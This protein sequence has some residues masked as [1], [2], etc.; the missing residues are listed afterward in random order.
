MLIKK[1]FFDYKYLLLIKSLFAKF[2]FALG[3]ISF[4]LLISVFIYYF[5][6]GLSKTYGLKTVIIK[7]NEKILDRYKRIN[8]LKKNEY[9]DLVKIKIKY[10]LI[11]PEI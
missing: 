10:L 3:S 1:K 7:V 9:I 4:I 8:I 5:S 2:L 6:S 11:K